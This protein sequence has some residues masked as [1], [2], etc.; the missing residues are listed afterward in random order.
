MEQNETFKSVEIKMKGLEHQLSLC[1]ETIKQCE[2]S[3]IERGEGEGEVRE[4]STQHPY[5]LY[6]IREGSREGD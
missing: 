6:F 5:S 2:Q 3:G 4:S 1:D